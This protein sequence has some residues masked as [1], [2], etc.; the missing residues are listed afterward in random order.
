MFVSLKQ[1]SRNVAESGYKS[2]VAVFGFR[3]EWLS[4]VLEVVYCWLDPLHRIFV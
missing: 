2:D 1:T 3:V 4:A